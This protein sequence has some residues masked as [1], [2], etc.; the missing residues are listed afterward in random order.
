MENII[1]FLG[2][3]T[4]TATMAQVSLFKH[5]W[6]RLGAMVALAVAVYW[7]YPFAIRQSTTD[8]EML[9]NNPF[10]M[11]DL[12]VI[13]V[14][15]ATVM[16]VISLF[17]LRDYYTP[18]KGPWA[19]ILKLQYLPALTAIIMLGYWEIHLFHMGVSL[20]FEQTAMLYGGGTALGL[21][22]GAYILRA[23]MKVRVL[24]LELKIAMHGAQFVL[25]VAT[26]VLMSLTPNRGT[27]M[28]SNAAAFGIFCVIVA[29]MFVL[30]VWQQKRKFKKKYLK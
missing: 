22:I 13:I 12:A 10:A 17:M 19:M 21:L 1:L 3:F 25:A 18:L 27:E 9:L 4:M 6:Q 26:S 7:F 28:E 2:I 30:G 23:L 24:R 15:E 16:V 20:P 11:Q 5:W 14:L 29:V 8:L